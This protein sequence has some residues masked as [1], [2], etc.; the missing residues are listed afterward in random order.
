MFLFCSY[1]MLALAVSMG[2]LSRKTRPGFRSDSYRAKCHCSRRDAGAAATC[3]DVAADS[4][5]EP[6][7][8]SGLAD[9]GTISH[10]HIK[11][12]LPDSAIT[13]PIGHVVP[14]AKAPT[15][16]EPMMPVPYWMAPTSAD[17]A[18]ARSG[19]IDSAPAIELATMNPVMPTNTKSGTTKLVSPPHPVRASIAS[20]R[21]CTQLFLAP[22]REQ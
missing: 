19:N 1:M 20:T 7:Y 5:P 18:P 3:R 21:Q 10:A 22:K 8:Y 11:L 15:M 17:T 9:A 12:P 6:F 16:A 4:S 13:H 2:E 14:S